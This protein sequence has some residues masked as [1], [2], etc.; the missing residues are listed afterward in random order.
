MTSGQIRHNG[1]SRI[2]CATGGRCAEGFRR[3]NGCESLP[4]MPCHSRVG[5]LANPSSPYRGLDALS[6]AWLG[7]GHSFLSMAV[8][9][10]RIDLMD[11]Y[12]D[13]SDDPMRQDRLVASLTL[14]RKLGDID[15]PVRDRL[16]EPHFLTDVDKQVSAHIGL[17]FDLNTAHK[18]GLGN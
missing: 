6:P 16:H 18:S 8:A 14:T 13:V 10:I 9:P 1:V 4:E 12:E 15:R 11:K 2:L 7:R 17:K 5:V 3:S